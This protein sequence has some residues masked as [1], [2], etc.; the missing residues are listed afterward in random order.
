MK[1]SKDKH[2]IVGSDGYNFVLDNGRKH[3]PKDLQVI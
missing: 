3:P 2:E 1:L